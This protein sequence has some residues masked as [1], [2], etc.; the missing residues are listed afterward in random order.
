MTTSTS[1][2]GVDTRTNIASLVDQLSLA[3]KASLCLGS[4]FWHTC[5]VGRLGIPS[6]M[7][8]PQALAALLRQV[9]TT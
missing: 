3:E 4:D 9:G 8:T 5:A 7:V 6:I 1:S 2:V